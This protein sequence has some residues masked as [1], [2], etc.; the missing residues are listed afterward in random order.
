MN[1]LNAVARFNANSD[2]A[3]LN[4]NRNPSNSNDGLGITCF[5]LEAL[6][7]KRHKS[8]YS[9]LCSDE[10]LFLA[11]S[12]ARRGKSRKQSV[13]EFDKN[14]EEN[15]QE[16]KEELVSLSYE[17]K[18]LKRFIVRD[19]KTRVIHASAF[20]DRIVHHA[21]VNL[22][23]P[24]YEKIFICD[25]YASRKNK[26]T[27]TAI[28]R[29]DKFKQQV[30]Q[31]GLIV[32]DKNPYLNKNS[33]QG[34]F[35]KADIY[36]YFDSVDHEI[37]IGILEK[38]IKDEKLIILIRK[39]LLNFNSAITGKSMP[40]GNYTSQFFANVYLNELDYF[41]KHELKAKFYIRYVDD[42]I[43]L[44][45]SKN[46]LEFLKNKIDLFLRIK[47]GLKLHPEKSDIFSLQ[48]GI[49]FLGYKTFYKYKI[50]RKRN[51]KY[52]CRKL[53]TILINYKE[54]NIDEE[55]VISQLQGWVGYARWANTFLLRK[56]IIFKTQNLFL[57][58]GYRSTKELDKLRTEQP[59]SISSLL[60]PPTPP[61]EGERIR[62]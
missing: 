4:C 41:V 48:K 12:R 33:V 42:F 49:A 31:N 11:Y 47:L 44:H 29:L 21:I 46:R 1:L 36:H 32:N 2:R 38:K 9:K 37:L 40:L 35:F 16:L 52:F 20:R 51:R 15:L 14:I 5:P 17:P 25:S 13:I 22:L 34:Y 57:S 18:N 56:K 39:V 58:N 3:N 53:D 59:T 27:H 26:G 60:T 10:N 62:R 6:K 55:K 50:L 23:E 19:P 54:G 28:G 45:R 30:S 8:L 7:M 61:R 43:I 24:I